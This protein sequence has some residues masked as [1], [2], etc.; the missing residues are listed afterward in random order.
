VKPVLRD[1][2]SGRWHVP[3]GH[4]FFLGDDR[5]NSCDSRT[6]GAVPRSSLVGPVLF[7]YWPPT[8]WRWF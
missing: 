1:H 6:W 3:A 4:Y 8:R 2:T 5:A 7:I